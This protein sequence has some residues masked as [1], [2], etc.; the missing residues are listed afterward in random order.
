MTDFKTVSWIFLAVYLAS[1]ERSANFKEI[2]QIA[3]GINHA[4]PTHKNLQDSL[5]WLQINGLIVKTGSSY[6]LTDGGKDCVLQSESK[7]LF[8]TWSKLEKALSTI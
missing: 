1:Q 2:S 3:D 8:D 4:V 5:T 7:T 6:S